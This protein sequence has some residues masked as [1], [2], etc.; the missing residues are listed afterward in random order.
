[1]YV[2]RPPSI[3]HVFSVHINSEAQRLNSNKQQYKINRN[4]NNSVKKLMNWVWGCWNQ[5]NP[6]I[7]CCNRTSVRNRR[8]L[9]PITSLSIPRLA[10]TSGRLYEGGAGGVFSSA[11]TSYGSLSGCRPGRWAGGGNPGWGWR[12]CGPSLFWWLPPVSSFVW[13]SGRPAP[14]WLSGSLPQCSGPAPYL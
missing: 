12:L 6:A 9:G 7:T 5:S 8:V 1:M 10:A 14:E 13:S 2:R 3:S 11:V 4:I